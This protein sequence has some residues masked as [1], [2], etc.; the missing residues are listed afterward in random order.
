M[1]SKPVSELLE[2]ILTSAHAIQTFVVNCSFGE[3]AS[4]LKTQSA[5]E[6]QFLIIAEA[7]KR[8]GPRA[9]ELCPAQD[10]RA[11]RSFG[12]IIRHD[13]DGVSHSEVWRSI[14]ERLPQLII[15]AEEA[16]KRIRG[17]TA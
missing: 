11:L 5:V 6:R 17:G 2:D 16:L 10:W 13:Y 4:D 1:P 12:N 7:A 15:D 8:L 14:N 9:D 3:Y